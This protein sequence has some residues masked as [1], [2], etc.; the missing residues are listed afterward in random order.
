MSLFKRA[1]KTTRIILR[2]NKAKYLF[3][4]W[5]DIAANTVSS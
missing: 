5:R 3:Q 1:K 2:N 4:T